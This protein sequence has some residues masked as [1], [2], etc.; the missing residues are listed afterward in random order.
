M[1]RAFGITDRP[2]RMTGGRG[3]S[4]SSGTI[5][6]K[7]VDDAAQAAWTAELVLRTEQRGFRLARP[8]TKTAL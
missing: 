6:L 8:I 7:P 4:W 2:A 1:L 3:T 5:V